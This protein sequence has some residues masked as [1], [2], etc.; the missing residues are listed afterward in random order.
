MNSL[1]ITLTSVTL[2]WV[3]QSSFMQNQAGMSQDPALPLDGGAWNLDGSVNIFMN[4]TFDSNSAA[5][6]GGAIAYSYQCY[7][8]LCKH[9]LP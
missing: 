4:N 6:T 1:G 9:H 3:S 8:G 5:G 2:V 7:T